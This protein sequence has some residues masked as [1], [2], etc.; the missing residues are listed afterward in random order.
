MGQNIHA[1]IEVKIYDEWHHF[2]APRVV[3]DYKLYGLLG[4]NRAEDAGLTPI[5]GITMGM[6]IDASTLTRVCL[7]QDA[8]RYGREAIRKE[9]RHIGPEQIRALQEAYEKA[10]PGKGW[11]ETDLEEGIFHAYING[12]AIASHDGFDDVRIIYWFD[13]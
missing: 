13:N 11:Q 6:P 12:N 5:E 7:E 8:Q 1:H 2:A 3:R 9:I 10:R 4:S